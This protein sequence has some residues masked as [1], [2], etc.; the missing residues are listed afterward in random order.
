MTN[1]FL[2]IKQNAKGWNWKKNIQLRKG[3]KTKLKD[4]K[5]RRM[6]FDIKTKWNQIPRDEIEYKINWKKDKKIKIK[7]MMIKIEKNIAEHLLFFS[8]TT[9]IPRLE[10]WDW[11]YFIKSKSGKTTK[12]IF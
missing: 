8:R 10:S 7:R 4:I 5:R 11:N 9:Q 2:Q 12:L 1:F 6:E 3:S